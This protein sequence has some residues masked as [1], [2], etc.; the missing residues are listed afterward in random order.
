MHGSSVVRR[1]LPLAVVI[2]VQLLIIAV[3]APSKAPGTTVAAGASD[4]LHQP[5]RHD[6]VG[7]FDDAE[8]DR[9]R[10]GPGRGRRDRPGHPR[11]LRR[12]RWWRR[13]R[14]RSRWRG[15]RCARRRHQPL[16]RRPPVRPRHRLLRAAVR[17]GVQRRQRRRHVPGRHRRHDHD[18]PLLRAG[19]ATPSTRSSASR[20]RTSRPTSTDSTTRRSRR[21]STRTTSCTAAGSR[22]SVFRATA[23]RSRRTTSACATRCA[24]SSTDEQPYLVQVEHVAVVGDVRR[25]QPPADAELR[26]LALPRLVQRGARAVPL[27]RADERHRHG[28]AT[29]AVVVPADGGAAD[30]VRRHPQQPREPQ[31]PAARARRHR[32]ERPREP[33]VGRDR[34]RRRPRQVRRRLRPEDVY[35]YAQ[36]ITTADQQRRA[37]VLRMRQGPAT[38]A[39]RVRRL[40]LCL[41]DLVAPS[42][43]YSEEQTQNY[44]PENI[45]VGSGF[46]DADVASQAYMGTL[47]CPLGPPVQLRGRLRPLVDRRAG[48]EVRRR[49]LPRVAGR[50]W[51]GQ[52]ADG[53][54]VGDRRVGLLQHD[55]QPHPEGGAEPDPAEHGGGRV[56]RR[57]AGR[58]RPPCPRVL[59]R[60][61][62]PGTR[63][64]GSSTGARRRRRRTTARPAAYVDVSAAASSSTSGLTSRSQVRR[65]RASRDGV[66]ARHRRTLGRDA[67]RA[68]CPTVPLG[69]ACRRSGSCVGGAARR[70]RRLVKLFEPT[71]ELILRHPRRRALRPRSRSASSSSTAR[72]RSS[73]S[74]WPP[75]AR[76][77]AILGVLLRDREGAELLRRLR[78]RPD[79]RPDARRRRRHR[80]HPP[81]PQAPR[82]I[83]TVATIGIAQILAFVGIYIPIWLGSDE[84]IVARSC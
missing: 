37:A 68:A 51:A 11:R 57:R 79:R 32:H 50:R 82:L 46:M 65:C 20:A 1:Y 70:L 71:K 14:R 64:C 58:R 28:P 59:R 16:R 29:P 66:A 13:E 35:F 33:G 3:L 53:V 34:P 31:R 77:P 80:R 60:A 78:R 74:R 40:R 15:R 39:R 84:G 49:R 44:Y 38:T 55:R 72:T 56:R 6:P 24:S 52:P 22:S 73:T 67:S 12:R 2:A 26:R 45:I 61:T 47:G 69:D 42:F 76:C 18:R 8:H 23:P 4:R 43:L 17:A 9:Q 83:L 21:S 75:S 36:D 27:G 25:A 48:A 41:C 81:L 30:R 62:T 10:P 5:V 7:R 63:T 54:G 19:A